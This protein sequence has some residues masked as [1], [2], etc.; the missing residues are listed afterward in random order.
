M[1][2]AADDDNVAKSYQTLKD[3]SPCEVTHP[4]MGGSFIEAA[5]GL[6]STIHDLLILYKAFI[7]AAYSEF[8]SGTDTLKAQ[9]S[10]NAE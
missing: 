8:E 1:S 2:W 4:L 3:L 9:Y 6:K 7:T 5:G 10:R